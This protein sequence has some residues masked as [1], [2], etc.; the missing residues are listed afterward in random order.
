MI[1]CGHVGQT[2][3]GLVVGDVPAKASA[4]ASIR[5]M[6]A[7]T[8]PDTPPDGPVREP[9]PSPEPDREP[10]FGDAPA[11]RYAVRRDAKYSLAGRYIWL[12]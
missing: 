10:D 3:Q 11:R 4:V 9:V 8:P 7:E 1:A 2:L 6:I 12:S 5:V